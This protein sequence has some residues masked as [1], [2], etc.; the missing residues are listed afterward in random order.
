MISSCHVATFRVLSS[1][2][3]DKDMEIS[4]PD[5]VKT[6]Q[7]GNEK[8]RELR[9]TQEECMDIDMIW[10]SDVELLNLINE[11]QQQKADDGDRDNLEKV[12]LEEHD[13]VTLKDKEMPEIVEKTRNS[14]V[15]DPQGANYDLCF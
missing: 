9:F 15:P 6:F 10:G 2:R 13:R 4:S 7:T 3:M 12:T 8:L 5:H 14:E 11:Y 1:R